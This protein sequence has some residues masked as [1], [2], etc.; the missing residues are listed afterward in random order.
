MAVTDSNVL[1]YGTTD[2]N[3]IS[4][5]RQAHSGINR[6]HWFSITLLYLYNPSIFSAYLRRTQAQRKKSAQ[7]KRRKLRDRHRKKKDLDITLDSIVTSGSDS[8]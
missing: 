5:E 2:P 3:V 4:G 7:E 1:R 6:S 8:E